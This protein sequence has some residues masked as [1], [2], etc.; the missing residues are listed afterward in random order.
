MGC[1]SWTARVLRSSPGARETIDLTGHL[2]GA[3]IVA[4]ALRR[5]AGHID[6][7]LDSFSVVVTA[8]DAGTGIDALQYYARSCTGFHTPPSAA[9]TSPVRNSCDS[10]AIESF[11]SHATRHSSGGSRAVVMSRRDCAVLRA[12]KGRQDTRRAGSWLVLRPYLFCA[13]VRALC[14]QRTQCCS[15][16]PPR[17]RPE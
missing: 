14:E 16:R 2:P 7:G 15:C 17:A 11:C 10:C 9:S 5:N 3:S 6:L 1:G 13:P 12:G 8:A 4:L